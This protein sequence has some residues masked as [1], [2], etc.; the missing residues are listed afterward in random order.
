MRQNICVGCSALFSSNPLKCVS[1]NNQEFK[2]RPAMVN[3]HSNELIFY[4]YSALLNK[5]SSSCN[6]FNISYANLCVPDV[7]KNMNIKVFNLAS[8]TM[9]MR[10]VSCHETCACKCR[11][12]ESVCNDKQR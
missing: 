2:V 6:D 7:V 10:V 8:R 3:I 9:K 1:T 12:D 4:P 5:C 11:F